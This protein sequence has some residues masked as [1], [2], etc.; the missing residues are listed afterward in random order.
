MARCYYCGRPDDY[1]WKPEECAH[2]QGCPTGLENSP[3]MKEWKKGYW[4][5]WNW[6]QEGNIPWWVLRTYSPSFQLGYRVGEALINDL[7]D[8]A[9]QAR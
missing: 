5:G 7:A 6:D 2:N 1:V 9:A 8:E 4:R 3:E